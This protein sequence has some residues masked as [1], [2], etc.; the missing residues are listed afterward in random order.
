MSIHEAVNGDRSPSDTKTAVPETKWTLKSIKWKQVWR[1]Q[2]HANMLLTTFLIVWVAISSFVFDPRIDNYYVY[3][4]EQNTSKRLRDSIHA[5][6]HTRIA[7][8]PLCQYPKKE[9][10]DH[11]WPLPRHVRRPCMPPKYIDVILL[12]EGFFSA[13]EGLRARAGNP[14]LRHVLPATYVAVAAQV[15]SPNQRERN[16]DFNP[17]YPIGQPSSYL[18]S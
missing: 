15:Q 9:R 18:R 17:R 5:L 10:H 16:E 2:D 11:R 7:T 13:P 12:T 4:G 8:S 3:D 6:I 1:R 14:W